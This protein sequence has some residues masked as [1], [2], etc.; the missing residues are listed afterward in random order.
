ML[1]ILQKTYP[2]A[3]SIHIQHKNIAYPR[4]V[5]KNNLSMYVRV[6]LHFSHTRLLDFVMNNHLWIEST[7]HKLKNNRINLQTCLENHNNQIL[8]FGKW[9]KLH[10]IHTLSPQALNLSP[11]TLDSI[12]KTSS[13]QARLK[14]LLFAYIGIKVDS[15]A[16]LMGLEYRSVKITQALS[17]FGSCSGKNRLCFSFMLIF[18]KQTLI[19]YVIIHELAH[20]V[21]KNHSKAFW[22]LVIQYCPDAKI[23]R[24]NLRQ[25]ARIYPALLQYLK[26]LE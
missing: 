22:N 3:L 6:P 25:E 14:A 12:P 17:R 21:H 15:Q 8:I 7:L 26:E 23:L 13:L 9:Y 16:M 19:D 11:N 20:I 5:I 24:E 1:N 18:A 4:I 2:N 10:Q